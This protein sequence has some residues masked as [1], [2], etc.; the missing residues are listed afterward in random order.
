MR[1]PSARCG[2]SVLQECAAESEIRCGSQAPLHRWPFAFRD[3][4]GTPEL[5]EVVE[6]GASA[7]DR[8]LVQMLARLYIRYRNE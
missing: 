4:A 7:R 8:F 5:I 3:S 2:Y 6:R 1:F